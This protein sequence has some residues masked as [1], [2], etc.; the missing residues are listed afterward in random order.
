MD[1]DIRSILN[2]LLEPFH[3]PSP[4]AG[5]RRVPHASGRET[6]EKPDV[7][8][9]AVQTRGANHVNPTRLHKAGENDERAIA[10][11]AVAAW[12]SIDAALSP[13]VGRRGVAALYKRSLHLTTAEYPW[14]ASASQAASEPG[15]FSALE[16]AIGQQAIADGRA[17]HAAVIKKFREM[18]ANLIGDSLTARLLQPVWTNVAN[19]LDAQDKS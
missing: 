8:H 13:V 14:L 5:T 2:D 3:E 17:A 12:T 6:P 16:Q 18:L 7:L 11:R 15:D 1:P 4:D 10:A 9:V 19:G